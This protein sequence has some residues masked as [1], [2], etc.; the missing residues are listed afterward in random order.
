L[1]FLAI[2]YNFSDPLSFFLQPE[3]EIEDLERICIPMVILA[4]FGIRLPNAAVSQLAFEPYLHVHGNYDELPGAVRV[5][6]VAEFKVQN[7]VAIVPVHDSAY[8][9]MV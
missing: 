4:I 7:M 5:F 1:Y 8:M 9:P 2:G 6:F 3:V